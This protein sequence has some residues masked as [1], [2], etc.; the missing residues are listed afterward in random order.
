MGLMIAYWHREGLDIYRI[1]NNRPVKYA[2]GSLEKLAP[3][4]KIADKKILIVGRERL[5]HIKKRYPPAPEETLKKAVGLEI[6]EIVPLPNP[7]HYCRVFGSYGT[8]IMMDIWAW[9]SDEYK[10]LKEIFPFGSVV[11]EDA[12]FTAPAAPEMT[13]YR[14]HDMAH[15]LVHGG[16]KFFGGKSFPSGTINQTELDRFIQGL[17][18]YRA[19][20]KK[21]KIYGTMPISAGDR[22][23]PEI[24]NV[25]DP[26]YPPCLDY[27]AFLEL[28]KF[29]VKRDYDLLQKKDFI[30]R[31]F[32][33]LVLG[34]ALMLYLT[35][36]NYDEA[37]YAIRQKITAIDKQVAAMSVDRQEAA[38]DQTGIA[39]ELNERLSARQSALSAMD[40]LARRLPPGSFVNRM[41][42]N[43][44]NTDVSIS[45]KEPLTVIRM[46]GDAPEVK[47]VS[48]KGPP[49][50]DRNTTLYNCNMTIEFI[51]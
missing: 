37:S 47:K 49:V 20:I 23:Y 25:P 33:Y 22:Q 17:F 45:S 5:F 10:R 30:F 15:V 44:N 39:K 11:P 40:T 29:K 43:E 14:Y 19:E 4:R 50:K 13:I 42:F 27:V 48:L 12:V 1:V 3:V 9:D 38:G 32:L 28:S 24:I 46:L 7:A 18:E 36:R 35:L 8:H 34:Y 21:I 6:S 41:V 26:P 31:I 16:G 51:R 2:A